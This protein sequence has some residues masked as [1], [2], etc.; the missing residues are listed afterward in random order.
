MQKD[1]NINLQLSESAYK[2]LV[3]GNGRIQGTIGLVSPTEGNFNEHVKSGARTGT[4][5]IRLR[6]GRASVGDTSVRLTLRIG[7]DEAD[8]IPSDIIADES[9]QASDFI[10]AIF[11]RASF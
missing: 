7:L 9:R 5:Y 8:V 3:S 11:D 1:M 4:K 10:D 2:R 6:H